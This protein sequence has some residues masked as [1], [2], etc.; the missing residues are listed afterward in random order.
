M[1]PP[2]SDS[3]FEFEAAGSESFKSY[4]TFEFPVEPGEA[5]DVRLTWDDPDAWLNVF[6]RDADGNLLD[7][8]T[9]PGGDSPKW[10][11]APAGAG[12]IYTVAVKIKQGSTAYTVSVNPDESPPQPRADYEFSAS[13]SE[14]SG[15][16]QVFKFDVEAGELVEAEVIWNDP[17]AEVKVFLRDETGAQVDRYADGGGSPAT[18]SA[19]AATAGRWSVAVRIVSGTIDYDVLVN[20]G[21]GTAP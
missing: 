12:G 11:S 2:A 19:T 9:D 21:G 15:S 4:R 10:L 18:L 16:W 20:T 13:G 3:D 6:L 14:T 8:D 7:S 17:D 5:V 1:L